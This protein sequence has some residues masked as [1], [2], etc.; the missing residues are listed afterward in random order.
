MNQE[1]SQELIGQ[2]IAKGVK[3]TA[4][5]ETP[6]GN[7]GVFPREETLQ[8]FYGKKHILEESVLPS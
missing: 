3:R 7:M 5:R 8:S 2:V 1:A 6:L 4:T